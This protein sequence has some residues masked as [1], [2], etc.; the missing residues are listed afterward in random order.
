[1]SNTVD[2]DGRENSYEIIHDDIVEASIENCVEM[3]Q[4]QRYVQCRTSRFREMLGTSGMAD[5]IPELNW[6]EDTTYVL[7]EFSVYA[8]ISSIV[9]EPMTQEVIE[10]GLKDKP[11]EYRAYF[12]QLKKCGTI[13]PSFQLPSDAEGPDVTES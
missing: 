7:V 5:Y 6:L 13:P 2:R 1:M 3:Q 12:E 11:A 9:G 8:V 4:L 10:D